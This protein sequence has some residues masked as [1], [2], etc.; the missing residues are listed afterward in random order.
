M[1]MIY[2]SLSGKGQGSSILH[3]WSL[4]FLSMLV[5]IPLG[6]PGFTPQPKDTQLVYLTSL[7]NTSLEGT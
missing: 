2:G 6:I 4:H 7:G 1:Y 5:G 3:V